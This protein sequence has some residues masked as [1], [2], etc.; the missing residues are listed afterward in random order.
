[1]PSKTLKSLKDHRD[2]RTGDYQRKLRERRMSSKNHCGLPH[3]TNNKFVVS[4]LFI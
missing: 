1:M 4:S 3:F 2:L